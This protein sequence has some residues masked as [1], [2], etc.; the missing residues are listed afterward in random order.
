PS[1]TQPTPRPPT[2]GPRP[3]P[4]QAPLDRRYP[5][6][7]GASAIS[8]LLLLVTAAVRAAPLDELRTMVEGG[9]AEEAYS[10][11]CADPDVST[12]PRGFDLWCGVAAVDLGRA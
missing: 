12:R 1:A 6:L 2:R 11:F 9:R 5:R 10:A 4:T 8:L 7:P 3:P